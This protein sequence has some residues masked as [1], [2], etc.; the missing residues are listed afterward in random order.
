MSSASLEAVLD[1]LPFL[2]DGIVLSGGEVF[3]K[4]AILRHA[5]SL[6]RGQKWRRFP[7]ASVD[8]QTNGFWARDADSAYQAMKEMLELGV[9]DIVIGS[10][11]GFHGEQG[12]DIEKLRMR[13][14]TPFDQA[15]QR[16]AAETGSACEYRQHNPARL[17]TIL[18]RKA[19]P[20]D[21][22]VISFLHVSNDGPVTPFGRARDLPEE[23]LEKDSE[24][25]LLGNKYNTEITIAPNGLAYPCCWKVTPALGSAVE[26][27]VPRLI[28]NAGKRRVLAHLLNDGPRGAAKAMGIYRKDDEFIYRINPCV[29]CEEIFRGIR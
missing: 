27:P 29:K 15:V 6:I 16:L 5:L 11:D 19:W 23:C 3:T 2:T 7:L 1:N 21:R 13:K 24:C 4:K 22:T 18:V 26:T 14:G 25:R 9:E 12:L 20:I 17:E 28:E 8:V 10:I